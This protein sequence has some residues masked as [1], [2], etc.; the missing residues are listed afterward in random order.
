MAWKEKLIIGQRVDAKRQRT[1]QRFEQSH[2]PRETKA[3]V[4]DCLGRQDLRSQ[5]VR[6]ERCRRNSGFHLEA[7]VT[8][9]RYADKRLKSQAESRGKPKR[10]VEAVV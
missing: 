1:Q 4:Q 8:F 6:D 7:F 10:S 5:G 3:G 9:L 2:T